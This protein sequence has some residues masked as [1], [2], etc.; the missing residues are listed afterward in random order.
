M[1][2]AKHKG[3][4]VRDMVDVF[5][6]SVGLIAKIGSILVHVEEGSGEGGHAYDWHAVRTLLAD[7]EVQEWLD[8]MRSKA[9]VPVKRR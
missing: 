4:S 5:A 8:G 9:L 2:M 1:S 7:R 6:P 3:A